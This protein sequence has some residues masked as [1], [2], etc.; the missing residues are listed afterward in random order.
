[1]FL[2]VFR[3]CWV[4]YFFDKEAESLIFRGVLR[5]V[6]THAT[7]VQGSCVVRSVVVTETKTTQKGTKREPEAF[8]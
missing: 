6:K 7:V 8:P 3:P 4:S 2:D 5:T 1:M